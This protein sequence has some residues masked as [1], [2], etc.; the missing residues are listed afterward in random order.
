MRSHDMSSQKHEAHA[1]TESSNK[2]S[3]SVAP[4]VTSPEAPPAPS[5]SAPGHFEGT[6]LGLLHPVGHNSLELFLQ[7]PWKKKL[8]PKTLLK[9]HLEEQ[10]AA[11]SGSSSGGCS[12]AELAHGHEH[13]HESSIIMNHAHDI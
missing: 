11:E 4:P 2:A 8:P 5:T 12:C 7:D 9:M 6:T 3:S 1:C 13:E 10:S